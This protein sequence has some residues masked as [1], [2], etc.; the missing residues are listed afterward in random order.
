MQLLLSLK[1][2]ASYAGLLLAPV[3]GFGQGLLFA[4]WAKQ[5]TYYAVLANFRPSW[6]PVGT[7]VTLK[8]IKKYW[9]N[10]TKN[11]KKSKKSKKSKKKKI[12]KKSGMTMMWF[13]W[14]FPSDKSVLSQVLDV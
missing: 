13:E 5:T 1:D 12:K 6:C 9:K 14:L 11:K 3:E 8:R 7:L 4:L 2:M 10:L